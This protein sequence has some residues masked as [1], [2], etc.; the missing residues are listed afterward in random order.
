VIDFGHEPDPVTIVKCEKCGRD[1]DAEGAHVPTWDDTY[2]AKEAKA[3]AD[4]A[5]ALVPYKGAIKVCQ[6][7]V[8][9]QWSTSR[10]EAKPKWVRTVKPR[11][12]GDGEEKLAVCGTHSKSH[13]A[14]RYRGETTKWNSFPPANEPLEDEY[15]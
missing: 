1:I 4:A 8:V 13:Y 7:Q 10:C 2:K 3:K 12:A 15:Q 9:S 11:W 6:A 5:A 14:G